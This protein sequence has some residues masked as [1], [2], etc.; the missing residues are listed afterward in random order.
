[1]GSIDSK[2]MIVHIRQGK[3]GKDR[4]VPLRPRLLETLR[5]YWRSKKP[6]TCLFPAG[7]ARRGDDHLT[8]KEVWYV[9]SE[10]ART[11]GLKKRVAPHML[12]HSFAT[13]LLESGALTI[14][15]CGH[16]ISSTSIFCIYRDGIWKRRSIRLSTCRFPAWRRPTI[17][18]TARGKK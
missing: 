18:T 8:D 12:R 5:E 4:D 6:K 10:A 14:Q 1:M 16:A 11:R 13:H 17:S 2:H 15:I 7:V 3:G 9:C